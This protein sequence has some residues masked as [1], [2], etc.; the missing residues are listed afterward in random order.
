MLEK[1][2]KMPR[3]TEY[4]KKMSVKTF[5]IRKIGGKTV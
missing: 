4:F 3:K 2:A 1:I 5:K